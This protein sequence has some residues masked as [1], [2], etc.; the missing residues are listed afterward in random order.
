MASFGESGL[1]GEE[2]SGSRGWLPGG[3]YLFLENG[4][5]IALGSGW[6]QSQVIGTSKIQTHIL[7]YSF[8]IIRVWTGSST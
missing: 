6:V 1:R 4:M 2:S 3:K 8:W 7:T 5:C